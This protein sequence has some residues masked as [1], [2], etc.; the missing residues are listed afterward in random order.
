MSLLSIRNLHVRLPTGAGTVHAVNGLSLDVAPGE[1]VGL[2]GESGCGKSTLG[3]AVLRLTPVT[4]GAVVFDGTDITRLN[5]LALKAVRPHMQMVFQDNLSALNP[6]R[7][8]G[9]SIAQ[10]LR[11][12][13]LPAAEAKARAVELMGRVGLPREA[14]DRFPNQFSGGQ[15]QR[16]GIARAI[17]LNP[18]LIVCD[19]PV[20]ALDPSVRAQIINLLQDLQQASGL[21]YLF[22]SHDL[23][24][25]EHVAD[26]IVVMYLGQVMEQGTRDSFWRRPLHPYTQALLAAVPLPKPGAIRTRTV[27][28]GE[29]P[30]NLHLP[31]GC[32]FQ[33]RCPIAVDR[34]RQETPALRRTSGGNDV[35]CHLVPDTEALPNPL[36]E[37]SHAQ[38]PDLHP[39]RLDRR[40]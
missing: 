13:G 15:R 17:A 16:I 3:R 29:L 34:C 1:T 22:I 19:E 21:S 14:F 4:S 35:A 9:D 18:K 5:E 7:S 40:S 30:S 10:P 28:E 32:P 6:R 12:S 2:I 11:L 20:S 23:A 8:A 25:V 37:P 33:G 26:R 24:V 39:L 31:R 38:H 36:E 27:L